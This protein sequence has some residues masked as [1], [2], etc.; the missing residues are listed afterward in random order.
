MSF[1]N[2]VLVQCDVVPEKELGFVCVLTCNGCPVSANAIEWIV[3][4]KLSGLSEMESIPAATKNS[5]KSG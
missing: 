5:A 1:G 2:C 3:R 4:T